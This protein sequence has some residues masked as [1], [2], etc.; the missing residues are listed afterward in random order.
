[1]VVFDWDGTVVDSVPGIALALQRTAEEHRL[2]VPD[3]R[4]ARHVI[5]LGM[6]DALALAVPEL[7]AAQLPAFLASYRNHYLALGPIDRPFDGIADLFDALRANGIRLAVATGKS[8]VGLSRAFE[9][10]GFAS[11]FELSRC[12]DEGHPKPHPWMLESISAQAGLPVSAVVMI[13]DTMLQLRSHVRSLQHVRK[14]QPRVCLG[15]GARPL[16][17]FRT[18]RLPHAPLH[19]HPHRLPD[20]SHAPSLVHSRTHLRGAT[21]GG[22]LGHDAVLCCN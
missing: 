21:E 4:M 12:A 16:H 2:G 11:R 9:A 19:L 17:R 18:H 1:M 8:R 6:R 15:L 13:G 7:S 20:R 10:T 3:D 14:P 5:G 22:S